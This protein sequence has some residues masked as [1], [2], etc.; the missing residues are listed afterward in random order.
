MKIDRAY[1]SVLGYLK[2]SMWRVV[3]SPILRFTESC[4]GC[5]GNQYMNRGF[6]LSWLQHLLEE[7][8][9]TLTATRNIQSS[10]LNRSINLNCMLLKR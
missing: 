3:N 7:V 8:M 4:T 10:E 6:S 5:P 1:K 2:E 9:L